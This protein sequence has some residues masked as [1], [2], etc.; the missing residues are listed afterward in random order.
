MPPKRGKGKKPGKGGNSAIAKLARARV[1][2]AEEQEAQKQAEQD[3]VELREWMEEF[4]LK[5]CA[6]VIQDEKDRIHREKEEEK[7]RLKAAG[8]YET[9]GQKQRRLAMEK[10]REQMIAAGQL[11]NADEA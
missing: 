4:L 9:K 7:A 10:K 2:D 8:L 3:S 11:P 1:A 5:V 6:K